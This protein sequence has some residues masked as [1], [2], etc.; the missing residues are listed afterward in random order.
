MRYIHLSAGK[1][2]FGCRMC[3]SA[4]NIPNHSMLLLGL[5]C[6]VIGR[7]TVGHVELATLGKKQLHN[8]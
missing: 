6:P 4:A 3:F 5:M 1:P 7:V 2:F 8:C